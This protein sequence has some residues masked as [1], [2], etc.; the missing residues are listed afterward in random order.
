MVE[1][2]RVLHRDGRAEL[3][4]LPEKILAASVP[5]SALPLTSSRDEQGGDAQAPVAGNS[6]ALVSNAGMGINLPDGGLDLKDYLSSIE[7]YLIREAL[8]RTGG[9]VAQAAKMLGLGR[10][11]LVEKMRKYSVQDQDLWARR[12]DAEAY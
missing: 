11:T 3:S 4:S 12:G 6:S 9:V 10:T 7:L 1:R 2:L 5:V 8:D